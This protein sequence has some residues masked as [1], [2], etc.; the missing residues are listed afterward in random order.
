MADWEVL[1]N[2]VIGLLVGFVLCGA[3]GSAIAAVK[4][5]RNWIGVDLDYFDVSRERIRQA[6]LEFTAPAAEQDEMFVR[7]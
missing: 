4:Q 7:G 6:A 3:A 2:I 1:V 5:E